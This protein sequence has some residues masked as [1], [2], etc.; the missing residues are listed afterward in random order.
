MPLRKQKSSEPLT[1]ARLERLALRYLDRFDSSVSNLRRVLRVAVKR[2][3]TK[4]QAPPPDAERWISELLE[5][6]QSSGLLDDARYAAALIRGFRARGASRRAIVHKLRARGVAQPTIDAALSEGERDTTDSELEAAALLVRRRKL[7]HYRPA[8][9]EQAR[10][11]R[12]LGVLARAGFSL[13]TARRALA[14]GSSADTEDD[15]F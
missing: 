9:E 4:E 15:V 14:L 1:P 10:R 7:G 6:Y 8:G 5:R 13:E 2:A 11:R 12:D 3:S